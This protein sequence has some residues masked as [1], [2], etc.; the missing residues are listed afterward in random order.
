MRLPEAA[1]EQGRK[2][3]QNTDWATVGVRGPV[4]TEKNEQW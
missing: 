3:R 2:R 1:H 4:V